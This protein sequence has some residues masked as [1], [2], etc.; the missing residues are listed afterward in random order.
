MKIPSF[1]F[2]SFEKAR[3]NG[4]VVFFGQQDNPGATAIINDFLSDVKNTNIQVVSTQM[5]NTGTR[6][7]RTQI[8]QTKGLGA[9]IYVLESNDSGTRNPPHA[10]IETGWHQHPSHF[11]GDLRIL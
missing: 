7:F 1:S 5:F 9:Q 3:H 6:D 2:R 8:A 11:D 10:A 4:K